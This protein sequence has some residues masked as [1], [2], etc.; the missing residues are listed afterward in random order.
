MKSK[1]ILMIFN[2][3]PYLT[4]FCS[5]YYCLSENIY[6]QTDLN[7]I[8]QFLQTHVLY[9]EDLPLNDERYSFLI[10][11]FM[12]EYIFENTHASLSGEILRT[13]TSSHQRCSVIKGVLRNLAKFIEKHLCQSLFFN[14]IAG[15]SLFTKLLGTTASGHCLNTSF[16]LIISSGIKG[17]DRAAA[18]W[19]ALW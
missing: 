6:F 19:S 17:G 16:T 3:L 18:R 15:V 12:T 4:R 13:L 8:L 1:V 11:R 10:V 5:L 14:K 9:C 7:F 2:M